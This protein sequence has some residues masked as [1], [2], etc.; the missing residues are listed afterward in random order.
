MA[1]TTPGIPTSGAGWEY[2]YDLITARRTALNKPPLMFPFGRR[3]TF[4]AV[5]V[6]K[7]CKDPTDAP[8]GITVSTDPLNPTV[9]ESGN[10]HNHESLRN[11]YVT[12]GGT[13][14]VTSE[15]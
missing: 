6:V 12:G 4:L 2:L 7:L 10:R 8:V 15:Y 1:E 13:L 9:F 14:E 3:N 5:G 11:W